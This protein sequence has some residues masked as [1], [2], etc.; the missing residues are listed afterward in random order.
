L[1]IYPQ[2]RLY[3]NFVNHIHFEKGVLNI[4][5]QA[6]N[7]FQLV[8]AAA[9]VQYFRHTKPTATVYL[10]AEVKDFAGKQINDLQ[11]AY[12][13]HYDE[14]KLLQTEIDIEKHQ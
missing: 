4:I 8:F 11:S 9:F 14:S 1:L 6:R 12:Q 10:K 5:K 2:G 3:S 13:Q 7:K